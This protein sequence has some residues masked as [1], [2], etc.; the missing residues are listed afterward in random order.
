MRFNTLSAW[1]H[2]QDTL[3]P[4]TIDLGLARVSAVAECLGLLNPSYTVITVAGT[5]GKGSSVA[6]LDSVYRAAG[7]RVG[8]YLSPHLL[9]YTER[10]CVQG[11]EVSEA[12][13]CAA[14]ARV[15]TARGEI[16]L[17]AFEFITLAALDIFSRAA[18]EIVV[19]EVGLG[20]RLD[21]VNILDAD[22]ALVTAL[23]LDHCA[24]LG[25]NIEQIAWEKAGIFRAGKP[26]V[27][28]AWPAPA[29]LV[30]HAAH[31]GATL[32]CLGQAF[33]Y[34][35]ADTDWTW[36]SQQPKAL[37]FS[38]PT[39][40]Q[41]YQYQNAAGVLQVLACLN[42][43]HPLEAAAIQAGLSSF[44]LPG[45]HQRL[46]HTPFTCIL[47]V[48]HNPLGTRAL[49]AVLAQHALTGRRHALVGMLADK[50]LAGSLEALVPLF[51]TW[52]LASLSGPRAA[53]AEAL[54]AV[55]AGLGVQH[56]QCYASVGLAYQQA[57]AQLSD[58]D[59]LVVFG[60]FHTVAGVLAHTG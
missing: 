57:A 49:A 6:L 59:C 26:A 18:L 11:E 54:A 39:L 22:A 4:S 27:C 37:A 34:E 19:L 50:D 13:L 29:S 14:F 17:T 16:S 35:L 51:D 30:A 52:H 43:R 20:G 28:S 41:A 60:S 31:L 12:Q 38:L 10:V 7:Y 3:H 23:G 42:D 1:L 46:S 5:N 33:D 2:W 44:A 55:L 9:R 45:R 48:A 56:Y 8:R 15:D 21:A 25:D 40:P 32:F 24:Y 58:Q 53:S 36:H 47:D